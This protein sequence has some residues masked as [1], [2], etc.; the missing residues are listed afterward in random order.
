CSAS[1]RGWWQ[2]SPITRET[3]KETVKTIARGMPDVFG[4]PAVT[5][6]RAF[7]HCTQGFC[8]GPWLVNPFGASS[9][10][11]VRASVRDRRMAVA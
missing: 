2:E 11:R 8:N 9:S 5:C 3:T 4:V 7:F 6:L 10:R 1:R